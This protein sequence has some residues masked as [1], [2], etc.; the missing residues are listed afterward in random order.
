MQQ[1]HNKQNTKCAERTEVYSRVCGFFRPIRQ[2]NAGKKEEFKF[3]N[4]YTIEQ[5]DYVKTE[6]N[7]AVILE[8]AVLV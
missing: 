5:D 1:D 3:R 4:L 2:W 6:E 8:E 7:A